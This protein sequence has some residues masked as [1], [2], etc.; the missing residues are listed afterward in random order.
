VTLLDDLIA[1]K[2]KDESESVLE[3]LRTLANDRL[4]TESE[5][6]ARAFEVVGG[7]PLANQRADERKRPHDDELPVWEP[8]DLG[9]AW[10]GEKVWPAASVFQRDDD[11]ALLLPGVNY[12][13]GDSGDGKSLLATVVTLT[14]LRAERA[15]VWVSYE[16]PN[17]ELIVGRL[18]QLGATW[19]EVERLHFFA[20]T[21]PLTTGVDHLAL[22]LDATEARLLVLDSVGEAMAVGGVNEDRDSEVGPWFRQTLRR[23]AELCPAVAVWPIDHAT[24]AKDN[25]LYPSGSKRKRAAATGRAFMLNV[26]QPFSVGAVG[27]V[28]LVVAKDRSGRFKRGDIA[29]EVMLDATEEPYRWTVK[30]P[31]TG[32]SYSPKVRRRAAAERVLEVLGETVVDLTA[33]AIA[34][35]ANGPDRL[36]PG[37][38]PLSIKVVK[39]ALAAMSEVEKTIVPN[40]DG[41]RQPVLWR[42]HLPDRDE[43]E[44]P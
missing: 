35:I 10:R 5:R 32:D 11:L 23:V 41:R 25:P 40:V 1:G 6:D 37:E 16:D 28:Q 22:L 39:N 12:N 19:A 18:R 43:G 42:L 36:Q 13:H 33:E 44:R 15:V 30:A 17:E 7:Y 34:R 27:Y 29:A 31:R 26:R 21:D 24:K 20:A 38:G 9:P 14:E 4:M 2:Y 3:D 8:V